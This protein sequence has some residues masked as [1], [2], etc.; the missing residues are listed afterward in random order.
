MKEMRP[1]FLIGNK[2]SGTSLLVRVL[3][4]HPNIFISHE[5]DVVWI[6]YQFHRQQPFVAHRWD[7]DRGMKHTVAAAGDLLQHSRRPEENFRAVICK[8]ME[9]GTPWLKPMHK[10][11]LRWIG[12][13]K[14]FQHID[15]DLVP[16]IRESFPDALFLHIVR[17]PCAVAA[18]S[19]SFNETGFGDFWLDLTL[20]QKVD[21]W[22]ENEELVRQMRDEMPERVHSLRYEDFCRHTS[23]ELERIFRFL[24]VPAD[25]NAMKEAAKGTLAGVRSYPKIKGSAETEQIAKRYGY[26]L[27]VGTSRWKARCEQSYW[28]WAKKFFS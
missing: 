8:L 23:Q 17:H 24:G 5:S 3:N 26:D 16:F 11:D 19:E 9:Q 22:A 21:R 1:L 13:K 6:L 10:P 14:P 27:G 12:D 25:E 4:L 20:E 28:K 7:S 15:P 2:R 18:S